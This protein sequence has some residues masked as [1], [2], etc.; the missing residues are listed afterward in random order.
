MNKLHNLKSFYDK[1]LVP[2]LQNIEKSR[3]SILVKIGLLIAA[4]AIFFPSAAYFI[5][6]HSEPIYILYFIPVFGLAA[7]G[8]YMMFESLI[9]NTSYYEEFKLHVIN[10]LIH[11]IN[12]TL[13]YDKKHFISQR[14]YFNSGFFQKAPIFMDGDDHV[15]GTVD[16]VKIEFS[17]LKAKFKSKDD[18]TKFGAK[19]QFRG[20][21]F[22]AESPKPFPADVV[23]EPSKVK[24]AGVGQVLKLNNEQ[25]NAYFQVRVLSEKQLH[26]AQQMFNEDFVS[27]IVAFKNQ[28]HNDV[29]ISFVYNKMYVAIA[30]D[31]DLFEPNVMTTS[32]NFDSIRVHFND[33]YFP[34]SIIEHFAAH[35]EFE[36]I[37]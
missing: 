33:L 8:F 18:R 35:K 7:A 16:N 36:V 5:V 11:F 29:Y 3:K 13:H 19:Y 25:F 27:K 4:L 9:K 12:P 23:I 2:E 17:E 1:E 34:I 6:T 32:L 14:E 26:E 15:S 10:K 22:V 21:F 37:N 24:G 30:H 20:I 28:L 31:K